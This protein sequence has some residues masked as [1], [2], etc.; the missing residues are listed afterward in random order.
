MSDDKKP[1]RKGP[2]DPDAGNSDVIALAARAEVLR[3]PAVTVGPEIPEAVLDVLRANDRLFDWFQ[4]RGRRSG[5]RSVEGYDMAVLLELVRSGIRDQSALATAIYHRNPLAR[6]KLDYL[7]R[8]TAAAL[9]QIRDT[10]GES[11][12]VR[13]V[14]VI[15]SEPPTYELHIE[16]KVL[17]CTVDDIMSPKRFQARYLAILHRVPAVPTGRGAEEAWV[18]FVN[19]L[20]DGAEHVATSDDESP[21]KFRCRAVEEQIDTLTLGPGSLDD[22]ERGCVIYREDTGKAHI[23]TAPLLQRMRPNFPAMTSQDLC[24]HLRH[25]GWEDDVIRFGKSTQRRSWACTKKIFVSYAWQK[26]VLG[27]EA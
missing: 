24:A 21:L 18:V 23:K 2:G 9:V 15:D 19:G 8:I 6:P 3:A 17:T 27:E 12:A 5:D 4:G 1:R 11:I 20:L 14:V 13:R 22:F 7:A 16:D 25:L 10:T 26:H